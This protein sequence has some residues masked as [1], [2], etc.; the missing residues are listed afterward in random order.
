MIKTIRNSNTNRVISISINGKR[1]SISKELCNALSN[2]EERS[3]RENEKIKAEAKQLS[4]ELED[5]SYV[6]QNENLRISLK[7]YSN[8]TI[9]D[10]ESSIE[11]LDASFKTGKREAL[12][13]INDFVEI[14]NH[15]QLKRNKSYEE[16]VIS[17]LKREDEAA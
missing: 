13:S 8:N 1:Y 4:S 14:F 16:K 2:E 11:F 3:R 15:I 9:N 7:F 6:E 12:S 5:I 17:K 10:N